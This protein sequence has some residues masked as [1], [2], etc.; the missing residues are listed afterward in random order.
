MVLA[1]PNTYSGLTLIASGTLRLGANNAVPPSSVVAVDSGATF[2][3]NNL[4]D[5]IGELQG[6]GNLILGSGFLTAGGT[7]ANANFSGT[8][9]STTGRLTKVGSGTMIL[10]GSFTNNL[11]TL[12]DA[13][14]LLVNGAQLDNHVIAEF[15]GTVGGVGTTAGEK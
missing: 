11:S 2:D 13:G 15:A 6:A 12:V 9:S 3:L 14:T 4:N 7:N 5:T 1:G 10:S 8:A